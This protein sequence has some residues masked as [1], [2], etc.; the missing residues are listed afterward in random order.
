MA[1]YLTKCENPTDGVKCDN[2]SPNRIGA[3]CNDGTANRAI[4]FGS[5]FHILEE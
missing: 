3:V 4:S 1:V 5:K 2:T